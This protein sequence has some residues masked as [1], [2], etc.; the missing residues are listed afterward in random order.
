MY[1]P[2]IAIKVLG[3]IIVISWYMKVKRRRRRKRE[4]YVGAEKI[5]VFI[6]TKNEVK[7][8]LKHTE[9]K[10]YLVSHDGKN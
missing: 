8:R 9:Y 4:K 3:I 1:L 10:N 7:E 2:I 5:Y 6:I